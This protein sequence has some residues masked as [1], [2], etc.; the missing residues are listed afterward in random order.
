MAS[1][2]SASTRLHRSAVRNNAEWCDTMCRLHGVD[3]TFED[4]VWSVP[5]RPPALYPDAVTLDPATS[6]DAVLGAIDASAGCTVKDSFGCL[7]LRPVG[8]GVLFD[9]W[10]I[11]REPGAAGSGTAAG[12]RWE[13]VRDAARLRAWEAAW[14]RDG[15]ESPLFPPA[16]LDDHA[17]VIVAG[18]RDGATLAGAIA[19]RSDTV[20]G[21]SNVFSV[22]DDLDAAWRGSVSALAGYAGDLPLVGY[23]HGANLA[24]AERC[25]FARLGPLRVW[26]MA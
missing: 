5:R 6:A 20:V 23:A 2:G 9:A 15:I 19:N 14:N 22:T 26:T 21:I 12:A 16:L 3:G 25:G 10:W 24:A 1:A 4:G 7:D 11:H 17:V 13:P 18:T 8:F